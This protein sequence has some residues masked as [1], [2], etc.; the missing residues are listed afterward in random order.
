LNQLTKKNY[1]VNNLAR[2][3]D[4]YRIAEVMAAIA[5]ILGIVFSIFSLAGQP[6][7]LGWIWVGGFGFTGFVWF[8]VGLIC[9]ILLLLV[10]LGSL[11]TKSETVIAGIVV[12]ILSLFVPGIAEI[13][14]IIAGVLF[15]I[16]AIA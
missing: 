7:G 2:K 14:G 3:S 9:S 11:F 4:L 6:I 15:I 13:I 1:L 16:D 5:G 8:L 10:G 12:I